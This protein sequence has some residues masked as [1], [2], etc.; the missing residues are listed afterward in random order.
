MCVYQNIR[1][2]F[3]GQKLTLQLEELKQKRYFDNGIKNVKYLGNTE[4]YKIL[5]RDL[6]QPES[7][8]RYTWFMD[9]TTML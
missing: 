3:N 4:N 1:Y 6:R 5:L 9:G 2:M 8:K 7:M